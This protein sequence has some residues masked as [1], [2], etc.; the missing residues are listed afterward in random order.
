VTFPK[1]YNNYTDRIEGSA[2]Y[3]TNE[4]L[5]RLEN[6]KSSEAITS[7]EHFKKSK[8]FLDLKE[9]LSLTIESYHLGAL[10][11]IVLDEKLPHWKKEV[12]KG[13]SPLELLALL[14]TKRREKPNFPLQ[15]EL[16]QISVKKMEQ[17]DG[18]GRLDESIKLLAN[19]EVLLL[20]IPMSEVESSGFTSS[21]MYQSFFNFRLISNVQF[22]KLLTP[23]NMKHEN[24]QT[25]IPSE[26]IWIMAKDHPCANQSLATVIPLKKGSFQYKNGRLQ[27]LAP[28]N[29]SLEVK[30]FDDRRIFCAKL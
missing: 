29:F 9:S 20:I 25:Q 17:I 24:W 16:I 27:V 15:N 11:G 10:A 4:Q 30:P 19:I 13:A 23:V 26:K 7:F 21:G 6:L 5:T 18:D 14:Q 1:E 8:K 22:I 12:R 2:E 3:Y 28:Y